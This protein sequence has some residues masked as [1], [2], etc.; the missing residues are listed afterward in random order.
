MTWKG[1]SH[2]L[3]LFLTTTPDSPRAPGR[4]VE[5]RVVLPKGSVQL[6]VLLLVAPWAY[7][8]VCWM[9]YDVLFRSASV[10]LSDWKPERCAVSTLGRQGPWGQIK[11]TA[12]FTEVP[13][14]WIDAGQVPPNRWFFGRV[15]KVQVKSLFRR[16]GLDA[17]LLQALN[18]EEIWETTSEGLWV[19]PSNDTVLTM[20]PRA[21]AMIYEVLSGYAEN[22]RQ[23]DV[24]VAGADRLTE[25]TRD[26]GLP[27]Q[28]VD[29]FRQLAYSRDDTVIF[30]DLEPVLALLPGSELDRKFA[31]MVSRHDTLMAEVVVLPDSDTARLTAYWGVGGRR[32][33]VGALVK[34]VRRFP[35]GGAIDVTRLLPPLPRRLVYTYPQIS[36][37]E[38]SSANSKFNCCWTALNFF[39]ASP[40]DRLADIET[41]LRAIGTDYDPVGEPTRLGDLIVIKD[42]Q[43][44]LVHVAAYVADDIAFTK[45]GID[46]TQPWIL[47]RLPDMI[48]SY[49]VRYPAKPPLN[50]SFCRRRGLVN[51]L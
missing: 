38:L 8:A 36:G 49:R 10:P 1:I 48:G 21:R 42:E 44:K 35:G 45:N 40:D 51:S 20:P 50:V 29:L 6:L 43:G 2:R 11:S 12:I 22:P 32:E 39:N 37:I 34:S 18:R 41:A 25:W 13:E 27:R 47:Q 24:H 15:P 31:G 7:M 19:K 3:G 23:R 28:C 9:A 14:E 17:E 26:S 4:F 30:A 5:V 33:V 46:Y 16:A